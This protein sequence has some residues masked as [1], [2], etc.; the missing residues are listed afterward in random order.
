MGQACPPSLVLKVVLNEPT[1]IIHGH[2]ETHTEQD[3]LEK[4]QAEIAFIGNPTRLP[5]HANLPHGFT[6]FVCS[7]HGFPDID[8]E[9]E[10]TD[11]DTLTLCVVIGWVETFA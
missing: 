8:W 3:V 1:C 9:P 6:H 4:F 11:T 7:A 10:Y 5:P 2:G